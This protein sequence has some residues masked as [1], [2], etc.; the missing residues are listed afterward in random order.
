M[1]SPTPLQPESE[2]EQLHRLIIENRSE[3]GSIDRSDQ[4]AMAD[5]IQAYIQANYISKE[6]VRAAVDGKR[7][8]WMKHK[9]EFKF[10]SSPETLK[11]IWNHMIDDISNSLGLGEDK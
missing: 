9:A 8:S 2:K 11:R 1:S 6:A 10:D 4:S 5:E 7:I 3:D